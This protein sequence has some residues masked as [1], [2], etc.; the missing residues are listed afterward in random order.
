[1]TNSARAASAAV[2]G[3]V[4]LLLAAALALPGCAFFREIGVGGDEPE[5]VERSYRGINPSSVMQLAQ[6]ALQDRYPMHQVDLYHGSLESSWIYGRYEERSRKAVRQ[7]VLMETEIEG[8]VIKV[9]LRVQQ[10]SSESAGR[11]GEREVDDWK[12]TAD[13]PMEA[14]R[15]LQRINVLMRD[16]AEPVV[17]PK[18]QGTK[19]TSAIQ[20][21][22]ER[23]G[24]PTVSS[25]SAS[26]RSMPASRGGP[27][28]A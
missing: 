22:K 5:W 11:S 8:D 12:K 14:K 6:T 19:T 10:E 23:R 17:D 9:K 18:A 16:V 13:D 2:A 4:S 27:K 3:V 24:A 15:L 26:V 1:M 20:S 21:S 25:W 28:P 7:R